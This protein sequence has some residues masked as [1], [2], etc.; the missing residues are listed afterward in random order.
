MAT[1]TAENGNTA[2]QRHALTKHRYILGRHPECD[3]VV[4]ENSVSRHHAQVFRVG[5]DFFVEDMHSRN[6]T[7]VNEQVVF[8]RRRLRTGDR[9]RVCE[10]AFVFEGE[11]APN[12]DASSSLA[13]LVDDDDGEDTK[14]S[15]IMSKLDVSSDGSGVRF[16]ATPEAKLKALLEIT[17]SLGKSLKMDQVLPQVL[18][19]LFN[20]FLQADRGFIVLRDSEGNLILRWTK[21]RREQS[22][23]TIRI[24]RTIVKEVVTTKQAILSA[25]AATDQRFEA[26]E[27]IVDFPI[28]SMMCAPLIDSDGNVMGV[29]Q[30]DTVD[31]RN[32]FRQEDLEV[33]ASVATQASVAIDNA[34]LHETL[35]EQRELARDLELAREVQVSFLPKNPP[36]RDGYGFFDFYEPANHI[37][38]DYY[39]YVPLPDGRLGIVIADVVGHGVPA[40]LLMAKLSA[41]VRFSFAMKSD[42]V[43][44]L[45]HL[46]ASLTPESF[47]GRFITLL[48]VI[49]D[50]QTHRL[51]VLNAGHPAPLMRRGSGAIE[52]IGVGYSGLPLMIDRAAKYRHC[53]TSFQPSD[54]LVM[55]TDGITEAVNAADEIYGQERLVQSLTSDDPCRTGQRIIEDIQQ[56]TTHR[57]AKD[58]MCVVCCGRNPS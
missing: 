27:S 36:Q 23:E 39:D 17:K 22:S 47:D 49:L 19:S 50:C 46:N 13:M 1:L 43:D 7:Y 32:R 8:G 56:F 45:M 4:D 9:I 54:C 55:T 52:S 35:L 41:S 12:D 10:V 11:Q 31:Q 3:I 58:D 15:T 30:I 16:S 2:G 37:G 21:L 33:L 42:P 26:S 51:T 48:M 25:D 5:E 40:A 44:A 28:R 14:M 18:T 6:G 38:G 24:S 57:P 53:E 34:K 29:I 20:I